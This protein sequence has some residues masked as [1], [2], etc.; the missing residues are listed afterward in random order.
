[1][2]LWKTECPASQITQNSPQW[3]CLT[4]TAW[5]RF[6]V[7]A[8]SFIGEPEKWMGHSKPYWACTLK[9]KLTWSQSCLVEGMCGKGIFQ[10]SPVPWACGKKEPFWWKPH[11]LRKILRQATLPTQKKSNQTKSNQIKC[12]WLI[13]GTLLSV[14]ESMASERQ[15]KHTCKPKAMFFSFQ[16]KFKYPVGSA[17]SRLGV[18]VQVLAIPRP[19]VGVT[20]PT[21]YYIP[22]SLD[23]GYRGIRGLGSHF[24]P[25]NR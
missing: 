2:G 10:H 20:L 19:G 23:V 6:P 11:L 22:D 5:V 17:L 13:D 8:H 3:K 9:E 12:S 16:H 14:Q 25:N 1:M 7:W 15:R 4:F 21:Q 24:W 18:G